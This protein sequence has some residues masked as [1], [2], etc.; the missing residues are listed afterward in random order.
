MEPEL[1]VPDLEDFNLKPYVSYRAKD[2][3]TPEFTARDLFE[4]VYAG[5]IVDKMMKDEPV[6]VKVDQKEILEAK[7]KALRPNA[8]LMEPNLDELNHFEVLSE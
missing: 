2:I 7:L 1:I 6:E 5:E 4:K 8:D 3:N